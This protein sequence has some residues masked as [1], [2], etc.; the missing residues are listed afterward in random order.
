[1]KK[2]ETPKL[3]TTLPSESQTG[4]PKHYQLMQAMAVARDMA[5]QNLGD[6]NRIAKQIEATCTGDLF[7]DVRQQCIEFRDSRDETARAELAAQIFD[8]LNKAREL[9]VVPAVAVGLPVTVTG[10]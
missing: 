1:M 9:Y 2:S 6:G 5:D 4:G 7:A 8:E 3:D 10:A